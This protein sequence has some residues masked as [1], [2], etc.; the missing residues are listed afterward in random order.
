MLRHMARTHGLPAKEI[1]APT[2]EM[3]KPRFAVSALA[4][5]GYECAECGCSFPETRAPKGPTPEKTRLEKIHIQREFA[6]HVCAERGWPPV[7]LK[8]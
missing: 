4:L 6:R 5:K 8:A 1:A 3:G 7:V 2:A